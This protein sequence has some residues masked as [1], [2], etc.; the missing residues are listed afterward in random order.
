MAIADTVD[1]LCLTGSGEGHGLGSQAQA[2]LLWSAPTRLLQTVRQSQSAK[3]GRCSL[4]LV[5]R[6][7]CEQ[8]VPCLAYDPQY[9]CGGS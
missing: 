2:Q 9:M 4:I 3:R 1:G 7:G 8:E 6:E 5:G